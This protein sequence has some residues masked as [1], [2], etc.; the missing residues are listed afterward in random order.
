MSIA[1]Q[2]KASENW[3]DE[4]TTRSAMMNQDGNSAQQMP[5]SKCE[6]HLEAKVEQERRRRYILIKEYNRLTSAVKER[7]DTLTQLR[8][9]IN[10][11]P[12][13]GESKDTVEWCQQIRQ[14]ENSR[15]KMKIKMKATERIQATYL[16]I[17]EHLKSELQAMDK[18][19]VQK[20]REVLRGQVKLEKAKKILECALPGVHNAV[21]EMVQMEDEFI[22]KGR[23]INGM[24][25]ELAAEKKE[26]KHLIELSAQSGF[27]EQLQ[28][29]EE[30]KAYL[31]SPTEFAQSA[32]D[33]QC[34]ASVSD[35]KLME[36]M[37]A[38]RE[39]LDF[40]DVQKAVKE[41]LLS[42][43]DLYE[44]EIRDKTRTLAELELH[45][46]ELKFRKNPVTTR[47]DKLKEERLEM[48]RQEKG[49]VQRL[50]TELHNSQ[51]QLDTI[52]QGVNNLYFLS[53]CGPVEEVISISCMDKL[54][55]I[56]L[57][58]QRLRH[59]TKTQRPASG[60]DRDR[61]YKLMED[62]TTQDMKNN[63]RPESPPDPLESSED[64]EGCCLTREELKRNS[65]RLIEAN[66]KK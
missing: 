2:M 61:V 60:V 55:D 39:A 34:D 57:H 5:V 21:D 18:V 54:E 56:R 9:V 66:Q 30:D 11:Q 53:S 40:A 52:K 64:E 28:G 42:E 62:I 44:E 49:R 41:Q 6:M 48:L 10:S 4:R 15:E 33:N 51:D 26:L 32:A 24:L 37:S 1:L 17:C 58:L 35:M 13:T 45:Y 23:E 31:A 25:Y 8:K 16:F 43:K 65:A 27:K 46:T 3:L 29:T 50:Q 19:M 36:D 63:R 22:A 12:A 20:E 14:L 38:L 47:L 59:R 7:R